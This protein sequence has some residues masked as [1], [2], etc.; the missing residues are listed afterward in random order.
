MAKFDSGY[1]VLTGILAA[2]SISACSTPRPATVAQVEPDLTPPAA[3]E[4]TIVAT[5]DIRGFVNRAE[6]L[7]TLLRRLHAAYGKHML[8]L[9]SGCLLQGTLESALSNGKAIVDLYNLFEVDAAAIGG[10]EFDF[11]PELP[12]W[13]DGIGALKAR[14]KEA[15]FAWLSANTVPVARPKCGKGDKKYCNALGFKTIFRPHAVFQRVGKKVCVIGATSPQTKPIT[16]PEYM[17][18]T[19]FLDV[20]PVV[21]AEA[22][23]LREK[24]S[25]DLVL[26]VLNGG[27]L[28]KS[29]KGSFEHVNDGFCLEHGARAEALALVEALPE[30]TLDAVVAGRTHVF[31]EET[32]KGTPIIEAGWL[33]RAVGVLHL[34]G[35]HGVNF[36]A[37][38][39]PLLHV[40]EI[41]E[42]PRASGVLK[43]YRDRA[44]DW[45]TR[46][47]GST[48]ETFTTD[49]DRENP[50]GNLI[51]D[52]LLAAGRKAGRADFALMN[53][54]ILRT[55]LPKGIV[56]Q[57]NV[58]DVVQFDYSLAVLEL[59]GAELR[60][61]VRIAM[62]GAQGL[63]SVAGLKIQRA[64][65]PPTA[66]D[67]DGKSKKNAWERNLVLSITDAQG[68]PIE[69]KRTYR[70]ATNNF[71][72]NGGDHLGIVL[73][74]I[75]R[76]RKRTF[77]GTNVR[78]VVADYLHEHPGASPATYYSPA[79][80]RIA[81][82]APDALQ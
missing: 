48:V 73:D 23:E 6:G 77:A 9:D 69:D 27:L 74:S 19:E 13:P 7:S 20:A 16:Q 49:Y 3:D 12:R 37:R 1:R 40:P 53:C 81:R 17:R 63:M 60:R 79:S 76:A 72:A 11:G 43:P 80:P 65:L 75:P 34:T 31:A 82:V 14:V 56:T 2:L 42:A 33:A 4:V 64:D 26:L 21:L 32:V 47:V 36:R 28:C 18:D 5:S 58:F 71:V 61:L 57:G 52:A 45:R 78:D 41:G 15:K 66:P 38:I 62:A 8:H 22:R 46:P 25:C 29:K 24:E 50:V 51:A 35:K 10:S 54:A 39:E 59:K 44:D 30:G 67:L 70:V 68:R 55:E